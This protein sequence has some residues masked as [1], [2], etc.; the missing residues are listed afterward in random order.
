M[1]WT[2]IRDSAVVAGALARSA[3]ERVAAK[4]PAAAQTH[5]RRRRRVTPLLRDRDGA[6]VTIG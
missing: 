3:L 5:H 4:K 2:G 1:A 6:G